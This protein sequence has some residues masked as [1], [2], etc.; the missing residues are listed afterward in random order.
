G[1]AAPGVEFRKG[2]V[3]RSETLPRALDGVR[4][5]V[6]CVQFPGFPVE[7]PSRG[8]TFLRVDAEG[9]TALV[10]A[11]V[12]AGVEKFVYISGV[13]A[14]PHSDR[15]WFRAKG[16]AETAVSD[17]GLAFTVVRPSWI[18]GPGDVSLNR[19]VD[20]IRLLPFAFPQLGSGEQRLNPVF[21]D[22]V[23]RLIG[24]CIASGTADGA[25]IEIGGREVLTLDEI[26]ETTM[27]AVGRVKPIVHIPLE[28][29]R[30]GGSV[31]ELLPGQLMSRDA[32]DFIVQSA[33][34][35][36]TELDR[37]F[38]GFELRSIEEAIAT[39]L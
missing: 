38:P 29:A 21:I 34:A 27:R 5:V 20:L 11:A 37:L 31:A 10:A 8:R 6:Q 4:A 30:L 25:T 23:A 2:D 17:S 9:T 18:Y 7:A 24:A 13:G 26:I 39:Y 14:D 22:D 1:G 35:D 16:I 19:F 3:T 12:E 33:I 15:D 36:L 28:L 32:I